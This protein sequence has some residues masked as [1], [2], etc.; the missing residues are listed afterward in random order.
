MLFG[1][2]GIRGPSNSLFTHQFCFDIGR[3][4]SLFLNKYKEDKAIAIGMDPRGSSPRIKDD[5][6][7][8]ILYEKREV[9]DEG[10]SP[11]PAINHILKIKPELSGSIMVS[12]SHIKADLNGIKFFAF[13]EEILKKHEIEIEEEYNGIKEK[14]EFIKIS[15]NIH[16]DNDA[17]ESY[18][19]NLLKIANKPYPP[20]KV[21][22]DCGD[23]AQSDI[24]PHIFKELGIEVIEMNCTIQGEFFARDTE[25]ES[26]MQDLMDKVKKEK[27]D[28]GI[29][30]DA[31]GDRVVFID[32]KGNFIPGDYTGTLIAKDIRSDS[33]VTP[34]N[35][36]DC[37]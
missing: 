28:F 9:Y 23:G 33:V 1:T 2:S 25:V 35:W 29:G 3:A 18:Q 36:K 34:I 6:I 8:G 26:N 19:E 30:Y 27:A 37:S 20:W 5:L 21:V 11:V 14:K 24:M 4:F 17:N 31:D 7:S 32:E 22:V 15:N 13:G 10:A 16:I 12:G